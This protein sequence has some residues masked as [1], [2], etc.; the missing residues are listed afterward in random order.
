MYAESFWRTPD[1]LSVR[2]GESGYT[3]LE[4]T[5]V[6]TIFVVMMLAVGSALGAGGE[7]YGDGLF[8]ADL[9]AHARRVL[10]RIVAE[11]GETQS[12]SPDFGVGNSFVT[13]NRV[14]GLTPVGPVYGPERVISF[15]PGY[16]KIAMAIV[17]TG[18]SEDFTSHASALVFNRA[19]S[20]LTIT[21]SISKVDAHGTT[22]IQ[23]VVGDL[24]LHR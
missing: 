7:V 13:Y 19:G 21:V 20:R 17:G 15:N 14:T 8:R 16:S 2:R 10:N 22:V 11:M 23:T 9:N 4:V 6:M 12:D 3:I 1:A 5:V 24:N 18:Q